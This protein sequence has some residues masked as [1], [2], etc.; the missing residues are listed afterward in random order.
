[1]LTLIGNVLANTIPTTIYQN[2]T[3]DSTAVIDQFIDIT[4]QLNQQHYQELLR[5]LDMLQLLLLVTDIAA[6]QT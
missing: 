2:V 6:F 4:I 1:M 5:L 3:D